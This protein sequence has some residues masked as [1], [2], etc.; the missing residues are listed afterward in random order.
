[1][2]EKATGKVLDTHFISPACFV[3]HHI[4]AYEE[5]GIKTLFN[6]IIIIIADIIT[7]YI[8]VCIILHE[9]RSHCG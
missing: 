4:N 1:M 3:F 7:M 2:I 9:H 8:C 5:E 6:Y